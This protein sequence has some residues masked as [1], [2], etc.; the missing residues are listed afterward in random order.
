MKIKTLI[1]SLLL[2]FA[3]STGAVAATLQ[4][5]EFTFDSEAIVFG[6]EVGDL[7]QSQGLT[8]LYC[9][10]VV[11]AI[12]ATE[13]VTCYNNEGQQNLA[14]H[15]A[16]AIDQQYFWP[17]HV[18]GKA[19]AVRV[20]FRVILAA[21]DG[22]INATVLPNLGAMQDV[23]GPNY[24]E[25]QERLDNNGWYAHFADNQRQTS[26]LAPFFAHA[27]GMVRAVATVTQSGEALAAGVVQADR[28]YRNSAKN[29]SNS[30][31]Q[32]KFIPGH[33]DGTP[34]SMPYLAVVSFE[35]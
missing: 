19:I 2:T 11:S 14:D 25:P 4:H 30:L 28:A 26:K 17:A 22:R 3:G 31:N 16:Q 15:V 23:Y 18:N 27:D 33:V 35:K 24:V 21:K 7:K 6:L 29:L 10:A 9:Q 13:G 20:N 5:A 32:A 34:V 1:Y 12:G 8:A